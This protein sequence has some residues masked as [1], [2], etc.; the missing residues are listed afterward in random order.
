M[1]SSRLR[2]N[3]SSCLQ[4]FAC[5]PGKSVVTAQIPS[6]TDR[7]ASSGMIRVFRLRIVH[8][9]SL[10]PIDVRFFP[11]QDGYHLPLIVV[12]VIGLKSLKFKSAANLPA[13]PAKAS[14]RLGTL[15]R[16]H[17]CHY[18]PSTAPRQAVK[19]PSLQSCP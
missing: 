10:F 13:Y 3:G 1:K 7:K 4:E 18:S 12:L 15:R 6:L 14:S 16:F 19:P 2:V 8:P 17:G 9:Y 5:E 11:V